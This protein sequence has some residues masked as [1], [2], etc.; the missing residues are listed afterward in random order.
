MARG[1]RR[2]R[3]LVGGLEAWTQAGGAVETIGP[4]EAGQPV[5]S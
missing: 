2:V 5:T 1:Y 3:P 4:A